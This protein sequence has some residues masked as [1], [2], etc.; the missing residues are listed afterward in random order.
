MTSTPD[1]SSYPEKP[2]PTY[3]PPERSKIL[4][5]EEGQQLVTDSVTVVAM[6]G[7]DTVEILCQCTEAVPDT[8]DCQLS[9]TPIEDGAI[10]T[11]LPIRGCKACGTRINIPK[12]AVRLESGR[13]LR[14]LLL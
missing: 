5:L 1:E 3:E 10:A 11:C 13:T 14:M 12:H 4:I 9:L 8:P 7:K 6:R 2:T